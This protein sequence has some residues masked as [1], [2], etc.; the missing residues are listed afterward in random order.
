MITQEAVSW[1]EKLWAGGKVDEMLK[2]NPRA[3]WEKDPGGKKND[4]RQIHS[5]NPFVN[6]LSWN[7]PSLEQRGKDAVRN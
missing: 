6:G 1:S 5:G 4:T 7:E 3:A 2:K